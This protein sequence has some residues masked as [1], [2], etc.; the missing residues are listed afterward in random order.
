MA[1]S[2]RRACRPS[3][4]RPAGSAAARRQ[5]SGGL[6]HACAQ[7]R[8]EPREVGAAAATRARAASPVRGCASAR[9][10]ACRNIRL[11]PGLRELAVPR[12][13]AVLVVAGQREAEVR[14]MHADLVGAAR[15]RS[16]A[17]S[18][19][20]GGSRSGHR[21]RARNIVLRVLALVLDPHATLAVARRVAM[22]GERRRA[23]RVAPAAARQDQVALV[24]LARPRTPRA[25]RP[26]PRA[27]SRP[28]A[29]P[30]C[31]GRAG[32][33]A[34]GSAPGV[35]RPQALDDADARCRCRRARPAPAACRARSGRRPRTAQPAARRPW[36]PPP[37]A[38]PASA[39][40]P[41]RIGGMRT[42]S[43]SAS[44]ASGPDPAS[45]H[46]DLARAH[47]PVEVALRHA[48]ER[49]REE[50]VEP[51]PGRRLVD[52]DLAHGIVA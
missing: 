8:D 14:E 44:R 20:S 19:A 2:S 28:A 37:P 6:R 33:R 45:V 40:W 38:R 17:S 11:R 9:R 10:C 23:L 52:R 49:P 31:R 43:P 15:C 36:P 35:G 12:E 29:R 47:D 39:G 30:R 16:S 5:P 50:I 1:P 32:G 24:D 7:R 3:R 25:A 41:M 48:F 21:S 46:P 26:A 42:W 51:L 18:S 34:R 27:S 13:V 4:T 22:D